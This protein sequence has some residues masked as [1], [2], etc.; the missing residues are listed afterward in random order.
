[1]DKKCC[2]NCNKI[3][4]KNS[5]SSYFWNKKRFCSRKCK[6]SHK[7]FKCICRNCKKI[8][9]IRKRDINIGRGQFCSRQCSA[10]H[11]GQL[12]HKLYSKKVK[13]F[14]CKRKYSIG[15]ARIQEHKKLKHRFFCS[16]VC[17]KES[18]TAINS[19]CHYCKKPLHREESRLKSYENQYC[20]LKC[21]YKGLEDLK[22]KR[23]CLTCKKTFFL[24]KSELK[25]GPGKY[26]S[27]KCYYPDAEI[28]KVRCYNCNKIIKKYKSRLNTYN[29]CS[30]NC[31]TQKQEFGW[32]IISKGLDGYTYSSKIEAL[33]ANF[34][35]THK[36]KYKRSVPIVKSRNWTCDFLVK[37]KNKDIWIEVDG[38]DTSR[39]TPYYDEKGKPSYEKIKFLSSKG[40]NFMV[41]RDTDFTKKCKS[42]CNIYS[43][44]YEKPFMKT[45]SI[46]DLR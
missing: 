36:L 13:C 30:K 43:V 9:Y 21:K 46:K 23:K 12:R 7:S 14:N 6:D 3:F 28:I 10:A 24:R 44:N 35:F 15:I 2:E 25:K 18:R 37:S 8:F 4:Y 20:S 26:C 34:L 31:F 40:Y 27:R 45:F 16:K 17:E 11:G 41:I 33:F 22:I 1:M 29:F 42:I 39:R 38:M 19:F 32:G 5:T